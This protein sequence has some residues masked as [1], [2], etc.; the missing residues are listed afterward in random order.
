MYK[1]WYQRFVYLKF[2]KL[3]NLYKIIIL[4]KLI[5]IVYN[6]D[7]I[8]KVYVLIKFINN[9]N[10]EISKYKI[11]IFNLILVNICDFLS[12]FCNNYIYFLKIINNHS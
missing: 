6:H 2:I 9:K 1:L 12:L 5:L 7:D 3:R 10:Y 8:Y 11:A 4:K